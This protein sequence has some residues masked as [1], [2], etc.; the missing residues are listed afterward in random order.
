MSPVR[1][2]DAPDKGVTRRRR[3]RVTRRRLAVAA[4]VAAVVVVLAVIVAHLYV[5]WLWFGEVGLRT[6]FW[7]RLAIGVVTAV[8]F[9]AVFFSSST[10]TS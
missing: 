2:R 7:K 6:V 9:A 4:A 10:A 1:S 8:G 5:D 3:R